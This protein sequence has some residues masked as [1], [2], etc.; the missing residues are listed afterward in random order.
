MLNNS[1]LRKNVRV[2]NKIDEFY[3]LIYH[4]AIHKG[5]FRN[6]TL[7]SLNKLAKN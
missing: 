3:S 4:E 1:I 5:H 6:S 2:L 7:K